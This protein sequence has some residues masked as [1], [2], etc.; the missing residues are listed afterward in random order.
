MRAISQKTIVTILLGWLLTPTL[1][2]ASA[3]LFYKLIIGLI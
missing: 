1:A 2:A 3:Y